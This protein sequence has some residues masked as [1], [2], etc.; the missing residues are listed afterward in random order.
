MKNSKAR[1]SSTFFPPL[2]STNR[3]TIDGKDELIRDEKINS[4]ET[5]PRMV[6]KLFISESTNKRDITNKLIQETTAQEDIMEYDLKRMMTSLYDIDEMSSEELYTSLRR[7]TENPRQPFSF[8]ANISNE[9]SDG[10]QSSME[11]GTTEIDI[12]LA[13]VAKHIESS[14]ILLDKAKS[15]VEDIR[16]RAE[17]NVCPSSEINGYYDDKTKIE[18]K[19]QSS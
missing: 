17:Q 14:K 11:T 3:Q 15:Y 10:N 8:L 7:I 9:F 19:E 16:L 2:Q 4:V 13:A 18:K 5:L 12:Q 1:S 6:D